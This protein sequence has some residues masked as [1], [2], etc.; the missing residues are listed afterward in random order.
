MLGSKVKPNSQIF[1]QTQWCG[2]INYIMEQFQVR[3]AGSASY[4]VVG[5]HSDCKVATLSGK[6]CCSE[7]YLLVVGVKRVCVYSVW[8]LTS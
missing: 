6:I 2:L 4:N 5:F 8:R 7:V 1:Y 3:G